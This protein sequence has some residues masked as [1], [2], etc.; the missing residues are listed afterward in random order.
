MS[1]IETLA[2]IILFVIGF[3]AICFLLNIVWILIKVSLLLIAHVV[4]KVF[5]SFEKYIVDK[6]PDTED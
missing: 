1:N 6:I 3:F 5:P 2:G 4:G